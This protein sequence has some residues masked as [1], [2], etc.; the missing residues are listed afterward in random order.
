M[1]AEP[2]AEKDMYRYGTPVVF[3]EEEE[4]ISN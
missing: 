4:M 2:A 3:L 1:N